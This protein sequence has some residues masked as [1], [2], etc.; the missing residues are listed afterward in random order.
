MSEEFGGCA[1]GFEYDPR[2]RACVVKRK[3]VG[4]PTDQAGMCKQGWTLDPKLN[5]CVKPLQHEECGSGFYHDPEKGVCSKK[6]DCKEGFTFNENIMACVRKQP[7]CKTGFVWDSEHNACSRIDQM[8]GE[9]CPIDSD[10]DSRAGVCVPKK[11]HVIPNVLIEVPKPPYT[12]VLWRFSHDDPI[13]H[14]S[15]YNL[16]KATVGDWQRSQYGKDVRSCSEGGQFPFLVTDGVD[17]IRV[18][19]GRYPLKY[20]YQIAEEIYGRPVIDAVSKRP[21]PE[22]IGRNLMLH[23]RFSVDWDDVGPLV[24]EGRHRVLYVVSPYTG[25]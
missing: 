16:N 11:T 15:D 19:P 25:R 22:A 24:I 10:F 20:L 17:V 13:L 12:S 4:R 18:G 3:L 14:N 5:A 7:E 6:P 2:I 8:S 23:V 9:S 21:L 1:P